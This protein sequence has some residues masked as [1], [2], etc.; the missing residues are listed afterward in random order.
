MTVISDNP[1][2]TLF[3]QEVLGNGHLRGLDPINSAVIDYAPTANLLN[4]KFYVKVVSLVDAMVDKTDRDKLLLMSLLGKN[5]G[6]AGVGD[7]LLLLSLLQ[8]GGRQALDQDSMRLLLLTR[9]AGTGAG[10]AADVLILQ[11][12]MQ[13]LQRTGGSA[14]GANPSAVTGPDGSPT[15]GAGRTASANDPTSGGDRQ[16]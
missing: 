5:D 12:L 10:G 13:G 7:N 14:G 15:R 6:R 4:L 3:V 11:H 1:L 16:P 8:F 9:G 2:R